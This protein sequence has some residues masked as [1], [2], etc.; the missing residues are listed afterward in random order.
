MLTTILLT[1]AGVLVASVVSRV[2]PQLRQQHAVKSSILVN[3]HAG[4]LLFCGFHHFRLPN[5]RP[6]VKI[7]SM[8]VLPLSH[9]RQTL[10]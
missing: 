7:L 2:G 6:S 3:C 5:R 9:P 4:I 8:Y 1:N 10:S